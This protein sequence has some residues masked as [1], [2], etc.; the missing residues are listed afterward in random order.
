MAAKDDI[1]VKLTELGVPADL[2]DAIV[3]AID[4]AGYQ[5]EDKATSTAQVITTSVQGQRSLIVGMPGEYV[6]S[7]LV[8]DKGWLVAW[9]HQRKGGSVVRSNPVFIADFAASGALVT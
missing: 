5:I 4:T 6:L 8:P 7:V 2:I 9:E 3:Q 1:A